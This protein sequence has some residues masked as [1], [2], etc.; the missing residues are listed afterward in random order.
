MG[1]TGGAHHGVVRMPP[2][3]TYGDADMVLM[4]QGQN[5]VY[6]RRPG[7]VADLVNNSAP[8][9]VGVAAPIRSVTVIDTETG[10]T[11]QWRD[12]YRDG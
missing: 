8:I 11:S 10:L 6:F 5:H 1:Q 9:A 2:S 3:T 4:V 7:R 12:S